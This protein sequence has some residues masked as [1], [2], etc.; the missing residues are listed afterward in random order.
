MDTTGLEVRFDYV[1]IKASFEC[2]LQNLFN[3]LFIINSVVY[4]DL[5]LLSRVE[6][7]IS[8]VINVF[9]LFAC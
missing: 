7:L 1:D 5:L 4:R 8:I 6:H 9:L 3:N 2:I